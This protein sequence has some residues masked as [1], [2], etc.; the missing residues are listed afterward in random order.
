MEY[1]MN[2]H[3]LRERDRLKQRIVTLGSS[4]DQQLQ[5]AIASITTRDAALAAAVNTANDVING[6]VVRHAK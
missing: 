2:V 6:Q 1:L 4:V 3:L 5:N